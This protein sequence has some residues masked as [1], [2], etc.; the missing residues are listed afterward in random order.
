[1]ARPKRDNTLDRPEPLFLGT[2][3]SNQELL[4]LLEHLGEPSELAFPED[5]DP[6]EGVNPVAVEALLDRTFKLDMMEKQ[7]REKYPDMDDLKIWVGFEALKD[8]CQKTL[9][10]NATVAELKA[11]TRHSTDDRLRRA[12]G[13]PSLFLW[14][15]DTDIPYLGG[16]GAD[17]DIV[18]HALGEGGQR[19]AL[20]TELRDTGVGGIR[21]LAAVA[22]FI[23]SKKSTDVV[24]RQLA[25]TP[26]ELV[27]NKTGDDHGNIECPL[28]GFAAPYELKK[29]SSKKTALASMMNH[30][31]TPESRKDQ[32]HI[33]LKRLES[34]RAGRGQRAVNE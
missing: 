27:Y 4:F 20:H 18:M 14:D 28:C 24:N 8:I 5:E 31:K 1:M 7:A 26:N 23:H 19:I 22:K 34:G 2:T 10:W 33:L 17:A 30:L 13:A 9:D 21:S 32:H 6:P 29:T 11:R 12:A 3:Y 25:M 16:V 15:P